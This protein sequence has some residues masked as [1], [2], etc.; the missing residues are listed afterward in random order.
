MVDSG[1]KSL[2]EQKVMEILEK[3]IRDDGGKRNFDA[4][5]LKRYLRGWVCYIT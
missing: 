3:R 2:D 4:P 1:W 5:S